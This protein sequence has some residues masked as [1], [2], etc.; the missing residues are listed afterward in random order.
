[1]VFLIKL[2]T[3][4]L[5]IFS[6]NSSEETQRHLNKRPMVLNGHLSI[7]NSTLT[8]CQKDSYFHINRLII[9]SIKINNGRGKLHYN[10]LIQ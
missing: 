5:D 4:D 1:M 3:R 7:R 9:E 8:S 2:R 10:P 6:N